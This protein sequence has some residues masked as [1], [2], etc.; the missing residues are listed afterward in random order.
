M[1][2]A[3]RGGIA[4]MASFLMM[5]AAVVIVATIGHC[6]DETETDS[7]SDHFQIVA[8]DVDTVGDDDWIPDGDRIELWFSTAL[9]G[10]EL[11]STQ[12]DGTPMRA[13]L[14]HQVRRHDGSEATRLV[15]DVDVRL[16]RIVTSSNDQTEEIR[17][18][19]TTDRLVMGSDPS[20][21]SLLHL[22]RRL[23]IEAIA[24]ATEKLGLRARIA[25]QGEEVL[26]D[27]IGDTED[28]E[29][30]N[31]LLAIDWAVDTAL[32]DD[33]RLETVLAETTG[34]EDADVAVAAGKALLDIEADR[35]AHL[36]LERTQQASRDQDYDL[37]IRLLPL[38]GKLDEK[39]ISI[40]L[41][42]VAEAH[43]ERRVR[44]VARSV[45]DEEQPAAEF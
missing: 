8:I 35:A 31:R 38:L 17:A 4:W 20:P 7:D 13:R 6:D 2:G 18:S 27:W 41:Q 26:L 25:T 42:T 33:T 15:V 3:M 24:A 37:H 36:L 29:P 12:R 22:S 19:A 10:D 43:D 34:D 11:L 40:Y 23:G 39:W 9:N 32:A 5:L 30:T 44:N 16:D 14:N 21:T 1:G 28:K 45:V